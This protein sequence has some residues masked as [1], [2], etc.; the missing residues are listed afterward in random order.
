M[1]LFVFNLNG[2]W[3]FQQIFLIFAI[4]FIQVF[5]CV[6]RTDVTHVNVFLLL[7][8][9][10]LFLQL[11]K[12]FLA[13]N[14]EWV[15]SFHVYLKMFYSLQLLC[16]PLRRYFMLKF[17]KHWIWILLEQIYHDVVAYFVVSL[18]ILIFWHLYIFLF[19]IL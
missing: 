2:W 10:L 18:N 7:S 14:V 13:R 17:C 1:E 4:H 19:I 11:F 6:C 9:L 16:F 15:L 12:L 5:N 3:L 8:D